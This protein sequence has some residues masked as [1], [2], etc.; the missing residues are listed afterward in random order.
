MAELTARTDYFKV[1]DTNTY[2]RVS[3]NSVAENGDLLNTYLTDKMVM[4]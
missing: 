4:T 2:M 1:Y 3:F